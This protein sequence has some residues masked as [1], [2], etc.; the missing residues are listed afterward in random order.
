MTMLPF[1]ELKESF[2]QHSTLKIIIAGS[3]R[4]QER[5]FTTQQRT[6]GR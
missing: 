5:I 6:A 3:I 1:A 4:K 2:H